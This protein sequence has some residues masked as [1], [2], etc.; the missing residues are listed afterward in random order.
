MEALVKSFR[1]HLR[2][3]NWTF[4]QYTLRFISD[5]V[6]CHVVSA[7]SLLQLYDTFME[8]ALEPNVPQVIFKAVKV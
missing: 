5:L 8:G 3:G 7:T 1:E 6:N 2:T 4:A